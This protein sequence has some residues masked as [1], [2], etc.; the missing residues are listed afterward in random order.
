MLLRGF[1]GE[2]YYAPIHNVRLNDYLFCLG[3]F[4]VLAAARF[5]DLPELLGGILMR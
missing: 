5:Y 3:S 4:A 2:F 1:D